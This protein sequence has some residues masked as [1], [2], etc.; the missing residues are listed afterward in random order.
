MLSQEGSEPLLFR[1]LV[2]KLVI[3]L[4]SRTTQMTFGRVSAKGTTGNCF[5]SDRLRNP[6]GLPQA[7]GGKPPRESF[8]IPLREPR[9]GWKR[10]NPERP[11][12]DSL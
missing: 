5:G 4:L 1:C 10:R 11:L 12:S 6:C 3:F 8:V 9:E 7:N 2:P